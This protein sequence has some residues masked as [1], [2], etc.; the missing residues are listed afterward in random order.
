M[1]LSRIHPEQLIAEA[2]ALRGLVARTGGRL[3]VNPNTVWESS[4]SELAAYDSLGFRVGAVSFQKRL[5][6]AGKQGIT[7][8]EFEN[9]LV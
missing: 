3:E 7:L 4:S 5:Q 1:W 8:R 6:L 9:L 2:R